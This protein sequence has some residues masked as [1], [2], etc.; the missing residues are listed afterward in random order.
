MT[1]RINIE[2]SMQIAQQKTDEIREDKPDLAA[3]LDELI[4]SIKAVADAI[5]EE[6]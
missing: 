5:G 4:V 2:E 3:L 1:K 6:G